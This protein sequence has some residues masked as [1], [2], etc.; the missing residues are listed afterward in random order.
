MRSSFL[1]LLIFALIFWV[2][3]GRAAQIVQHDIVHHDIEVTLDPRQGSIAVVDVITVALKDSREEAFGFFLNRNL[4][5]AEVAAVDE[6]L[7]I[8]I[9]VIPYQQALQDHFAAVDAAQVPD[10]AI[11]TYYQLIPAGQEARRAATLKLR[12]VYRGVIFDPL[13]PPASPAARGFMHTTRLIEEWG[14]YLTGATFWIPQRPGDLFTFTLRTALPEGYASVSQGTRTSH[15]VAAGV[16]RTQWHCPF[17]QQQIFLIAGKYVVTEERHGEV[18][19]MTFLYTSDPQINN[20]YIPATKRY[21]DLY[22][23]LI[24]PFPYRKFAL[25]ENY[26]QTGLGMPSFTL[27]GDQVI[28]LPFIVSTSYGHEIL[29]NWWGNSVYVDWATGN[30]SEGLTTYG[31]DYL[32]TERQNAEAA[33][34]YRRRILQDYLNYVHA[35]KELPLR[36]FRRQGSLASRAIGYGKAAMVFHMLRR[37]VGEE[38]YWAALRRFYQD[39]R[40]KVASWESIF[41]AFTA[42]TNRDLNAFKRHWIDQAGAP[43]ISL[44]AVTLKRARPSYL[45]EVVIAQ[46]PPYDL[47]IPL[48]IQTARATVR[49]TVA[50][51]EAVN[52]QQ[53]ILEDRPL[54]VH[55]DP[56]FDVFRRLHRAEVPPTLGQALGAASVLIVVPRRGDA[57]LVQ[58]YDQLASQW[59]QDK[60]YTA[61]KEGSYLAALPRN[62]TVWKFGLAELG[63]SGVLALPPGV[64]IT[65]DRWLIAGTPY[66][67]TQHSLVMTGAHSD[68]P[69]QTVNW[70]IASNPQWV[71][72]IGRKI[73]HYGKYSYLVFAKDAVVGKGI[74]PVPSSPLRQAIPFQ[75]DEGVR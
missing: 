48:H 41:S 29:H 11:A 16:V 70:L 64:S 28:R 50:L 69:D 6:D 18:D 24:G 46:S 4:E 32:Y 5:V 52:R 14:S 45:L 26:W 7:P 73:Q 74:W 60:R 71:P 51:A 47:E 34:E 35:D 33:R 12:L 27:L 53:F 68:H 31:A 40:F 9:Q 36:A 13:T 49:R 58:A 10:Y 15:E 63:D 43:F 57:A 2:G 8:T 75:A 72:A 39:F 67:S 20:V 1:L 38:D 21:L 55:V 22:S 42:I 17:P 61:V 62:T 59:A 37:L 65:A 44:E 19:I 54:A 25:V 3:S 30:W 23:R 56:D 66:D